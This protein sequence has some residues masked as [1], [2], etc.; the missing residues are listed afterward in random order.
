MMSGVPLETCWTFNKLWNNKFYYK[1][2]L[3]GISTESYYD[4]RV[5]EYQTHFTD[6]K[7]KEVFTDTVIDVSEKPVASTLLDNKPFRN[8]N[9]Q[10][11]ITALKAF[12][13]INMAT[14]S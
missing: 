1:L 11:A 5:H 7:Y 3:I 2:Q 9:Y 8:A 4:A 13:F 12:A 10:S 14:I 6:L